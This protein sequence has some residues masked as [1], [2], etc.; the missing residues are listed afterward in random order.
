MASPANTDTASHEPAPDDAPAVRT[1]AVD[2][3]VVA[4]ADA[5]DQ[6]ARPS[7][8]PLPPPPPLG[9]H[10]QV[11]ARAHAASSRVL[12]LPDRASTCPSRRSRRR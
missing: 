12:T 4:A 5:F 3:D 10:A 9:E 7:D 6:L 2:P 11:S 8:P 1:L